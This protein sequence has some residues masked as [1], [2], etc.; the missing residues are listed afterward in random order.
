[1]PTAFFQPGLLSGHSALITG[2]GT[3]ICRGIALAFAALGCDVAITSRKQEH[4]APT[5]AEIQRN[6]VRAL[7]VAGDVRRPDDVQAIAHDVLRHRILLS[8]DAQAEGIKANAVIDKMIQ[9]V[10]V[11]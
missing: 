1:V 3:G 4:L 10:A 5:V 11:A 6:G 2:G 8:Y 9:L 7:G